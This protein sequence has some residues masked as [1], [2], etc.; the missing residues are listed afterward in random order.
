MWRWLLGLLGAAVLVALGVWLGPGLLRQAESPIVVGLLHSR[1]GALALSETAMI[2]AEVLALEEI[3]KAG[4]L[5][6]RRVSWVIADGESDPMAFGREAHRLIETEKVS[7]IFGGMTSA[8]RQA[9]EDVVT[10]SDHLFVFPSNYEGM[11]F[12]QYV[13]C[14]GPLPNQQVI[15]AVNWCHE[16]LKARK[17]YLAGS[18]D[19]LSYAVHTIVKD[20]LKA[21]G[22]SFVGESF[23]TIEGGGMTEMIAA[24]KASGADVVFSSVVGDANKAFFRQMTQAGLTPEKLPVVCTGVTESELRELPVA[25][26]VGDY[27]AWG[28]FQT[29]DRPENRAFVAAFKE[30]YG[31]ER[32]TSD[33]IASAYNSVK[34]WAQAVQEAGTETVP[35][36]RQHLRR[37]SRNAAEGI[38][39][40]DYD[41]LHTW[42][43][44]YLGKIRR[45][46][47]FDI[48]W[49]LERPIRPVPYP[50]FRSRSYWEAAVEK[51][52]QAG[53][54][55]VVEPPAPVPVPV[56]VPPPAS[57][58]PPS[59]SISGPR[60]FIRPGSFEPPKAAARSNVTV[61][62][63]RATAR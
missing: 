49:S 8:C 15:P 50:M 45:D 5:L 46:G 25:E 60:N 31:N 62:R 26:M 12:S 3:N 43:P 40:I 55:G 24:I 29:V 35:E 58:S 16:T 9:V 1:T 17:F 37:Q 28:Y 30:R 63:T 32:P 6:G 33:P 52:N 4:G 7:V 54:R 51:W 10:P 18:A 47:Q 2:D 56:P 38:V 36:V 27:A 39:S 34:L 11:D 48:V 59:P 41:T 61:E 13:V 57:V 53:S 21:L 44:F 14:T 19:V 20:Q 22:A 42:R 23:V